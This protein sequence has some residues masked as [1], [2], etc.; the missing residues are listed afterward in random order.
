MREFLGYERADGSAGIRNLVLILPATRVTNLMAQRIESAVVNTKA[1]I[2]TG[3]YGRTISDRERLF[4]FL[5]GIATNPNVTGIVLLGVQEGYGYAEFQ[6]DRMVAAI[7]RGAPGKPLAVVE[8]AA[9]TIAFSDPLDV[10]Y[11]GPSV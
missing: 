11:Q 4:T 7:N 5:T 6:L 1:L 8:A 2:N 10:Y 3:E 9:E